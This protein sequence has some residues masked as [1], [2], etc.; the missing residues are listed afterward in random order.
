MLKRQKTTFAETKTQ[1][2]ELLSYFA[3]KDAAEK[4]TPETFFSNWGA[5]LD[6]Y[7]LEWERVQKRVAKEMFEKV[8][9]KRKVRPLWRQIASCRLRYVWGRLATRLIGKRSYNF[10]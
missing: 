3:F 6:D 2:K 10:F 1:F 4:I 7:K 9:E 8:E 5:F